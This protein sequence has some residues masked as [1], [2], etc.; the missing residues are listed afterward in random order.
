MPLFICFKTY[1]EVYM[2]RNYRDPEDIHLDEY[3]HNWDGSLR[4]SRFGNLPGAAQRGRDRRERVK[5]A[6]T[7]GA[8]VKA[9]L[10]II[11]L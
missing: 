6:T 2:Y 4:R 1:E 9:I 8:V 7:S 10:K 5:E 11:G 3:Q